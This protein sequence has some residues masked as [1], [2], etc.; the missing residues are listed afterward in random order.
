[1]EELLAD[2]LSLVARDLG[3]LDDLRGDRPLL[4]E[5][6][7]DRRD[8][9]RRT[10]SAARSTPGIATVSPESR[11]YWTIIIAWFRSSTAWR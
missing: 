3:E 10:G 6:E 8:E 11:R 9:R 1:M 2:E 7:R 5:R 4:L